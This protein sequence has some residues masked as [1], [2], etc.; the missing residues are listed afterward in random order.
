[1][2]KIY[3]VALIGC[4]RM[5]RAHI[6][7]IYSKD[8]LRFRYVCDKNLTRAAEFQQLYNADKITD[9]YMECVT[10]SD[11][12]I[13][14]IATLPATHLDIL[15]L[16]MENNKHVLCEKPIGCNRNDA[17][18]YQQLRRDYP[19][20]KVLIGHILRHNAT[21][22]RV[23]EMIQDGAIGS[24]IAF[25]MIQNHH[26]MDWKRFR[27][28][29]QDV[30]PL[31][32]C[33]V[34]YVD[35]IR[36]F[37]GQEVVSMNAVGARID[38][39]VPEGQYNHGII[40]MQLS[41]GSVGYYEAGFSKTLSSRN[42]KEFSGP[43]GR[44]SLIAAKDRCC[45]QEE[46]D[47]IEYYSYPDKQYHMINIPAKWKSTDVQFS[48]LIKMIE[49]NVPGLPTEEDAIC[50]FNHMLDADEMVRKSMGNL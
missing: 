48:H 15:Q 9:N 42:L 36:W 10:A 11:V 37:T 20:V 18:R 21:Y 25:R 49:E 35:I 33:G 34:H 40:T 30:S 44:I 12:D 28:L 16:C 32:D 22:Q 24:P 43:K 8:N 6:Q 26:A 7:E 47:L 13:V 50:A 38:E 31:L 4:G 14:I 23:A 19:H 5:G 17:V 1:M 29:L 41:D 46:G 27:G 45:H 2:K 39:D 3:N